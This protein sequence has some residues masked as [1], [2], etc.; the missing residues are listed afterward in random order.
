M[1]ELFDLSKLVG[2]LP[3]Q[4][5]IGLVILGAFGLSAYAIHAVLAVVTKD[6][7]P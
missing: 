2:S 7:D 1:S 5:L 6:R 4:A 3:I